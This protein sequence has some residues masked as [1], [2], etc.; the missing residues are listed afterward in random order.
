MTLNPYFTT[1]S[2]NIDLN[3]KQENYQT[4]R[5][6]EK[7]ICGL[8]IASSQTQYQRYDTLKKLIN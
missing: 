1:Y 5:K 3:V 2:F 8:W 7:N 6:Q 4:L